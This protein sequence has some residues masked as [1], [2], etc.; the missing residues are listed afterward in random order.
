MWA[1]DTGQGAQLC[2]T[3]PVGQLVLVH[4]SS[5]QGSGVGQGKI[6]FFKSLS[7]TPFFSIVPFDQTFD[8][9]GEHFLPQLLH[10]SE[11]FILFKL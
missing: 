7:I 4:P 11:E 9:L 2:L 3:S 6:I 5:G 10:K 8:I 1:Q